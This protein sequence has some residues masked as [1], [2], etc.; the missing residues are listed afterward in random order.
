MSSRR[1]GGTRDARARGIARALAV[2]DGRG[3]GRKLVAMK[4]R[5]IEHASDARQRRDVRSVA[6][7][8]TA[9]TACC[10]SGWTSAGVAAAR[11]RSG[12]ASAAARGA[13]ARR[14][15][16]HR[17]PRHRDRHRA[18]GARVVG[19]D[20]SAGML[21]I[22]RRKVVRAG[23]AERIGSRAATRRPLLAEGEFDAATIAFGIR[24][25]PDRATALRELARVVPTGRAHCGPRARRAARRAPRGAR[26][27]PRAR[28]GATRR[29]DGGAEEGVR[30]SRCAARG[31]CGAFPPAPEF[32]ETMRAAGLARVEATPLTFG[33]CTI[34]VGERGRT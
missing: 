25:V 29:R 10:R 31:R 13:R 4:S 22:A 17:G 11:R 14:G 27:A 24:N 15:D 20:P 2:P 21:A 30:L 1:A 6:P 12:R 28:R 8:T 34:F 19:L 7:V 33:V 18:S 26:P 23:L 32:A 5:V 3:A 9:S 16:R